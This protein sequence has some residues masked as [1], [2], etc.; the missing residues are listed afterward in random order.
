M[1]PVGAFVCSEI[2]NSLPP[3]RTT[4]TVV[5]EILDRDPVSGLYLV[6]YKNGTTRWRT[7]PEGRWEEC[8]DLSKP[9]GQ[10]SPPT[11]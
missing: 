5:V 7:L 6:R 3:R 8:V 9:P 4:Y 2:G 10:L 1:F 11:E